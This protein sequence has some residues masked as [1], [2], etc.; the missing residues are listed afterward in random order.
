MKPQKPSRFIQIAVF[1]FDTRNLDPKRSITKAR[2]INSH[3]TCMLLVL[4]GAADVDEGEAKLQEDQGIRAI[5]EAPD[6]PQHVTQQEEP[7]SPVALELFLRAHHPGSD[8]RD[9]HRRPLNSIENIHH[10]HSR[11]E[12]RRPH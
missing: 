8:D 5:V 11:S 6:D 7:E 2:S 3:E 10:L 4:Y 1:I 12:I 9:Y